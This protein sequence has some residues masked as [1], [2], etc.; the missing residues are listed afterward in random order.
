MI[1]RAN[2]TTCGLAA[3]VITNDI[4]KALKFI[5]SVKASSMWYE[6]VNKYWCNFNRKGVRT[7]K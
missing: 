1:G 7:M 5:N 4:N 6:R 2:D 3:G